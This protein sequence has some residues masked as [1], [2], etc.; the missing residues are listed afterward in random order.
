MYL[1]HVSAVHGPGMTGLVRGMA[2]SC[3]RKVSCQHA[4]NI[5]AA[6]PCRISKPVIPDPCT[7]LTC[8]TGMVARGLL[9][10]VVVTVMTADLKH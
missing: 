10:A 5:H 2:G 3:L 4:V 8:S 1:L 7:A 6:T 9:T